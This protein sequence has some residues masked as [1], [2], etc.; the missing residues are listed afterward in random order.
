MADYVLLPRVSKAATADTSGLNT[1]NLTNKFD[2]ND[3]GHQVSVFEV[4][5][6]NIAAKT[7]G[8]T[9]TPAPCTVYLD[10]QAYSFTFPV[11][12]TEWD[13]SQPMLC[14]QASELLFCW[15][16][17]SSV[18]PV[19]VVTIWRRY[20]R[21]LRANVDSVAGLLAPGEPGL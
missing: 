6:I 12:G 15:G 3:W 9:F 16:L 17:A 13:P 18:T 4:Y 7:A 1:G 11:G 14:R 2:P 21:A 20:D 10:R 8:T 5:H 19:P